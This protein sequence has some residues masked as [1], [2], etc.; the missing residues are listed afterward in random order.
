MEAALEGDNS[1]PARVRACELDRV[2]DR[3]G[4][5]VEERG[6]RVLD[7]SE[8]AEAFCQSDVDLVGDDGEIGVAEALELLLG[9]L[10]DPRMCVPDVQA[11]DTACEVD[12]GVAVD[13]GQRRALT[14]LDHE[15]GR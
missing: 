7:P 13:V 15:S 6:L 1:G 5:G 12:E 4:P 3:L 9:G 11:A 10:D 2:L 14:A 8:L